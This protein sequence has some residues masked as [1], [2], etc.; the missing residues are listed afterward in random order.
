MEKKYPSRGL[1]QKRLQKF[2][3][4]MTLKIFILSVSLSSI[5]VPG[6]SQSRYDVK[7][8]GQD[9]LDVLVWL[10]DNSNYRFIYRKDVVKDVKVG[11]LDM[12]QASMEQILDRVLIDNGFEYDLDADNVVVVRKSRVQAPQQTRQTVSVTGT[13]KDSNGNP[14]AGVSVIVKNTKN[15]V[16]TDASGNFRISMA[17]GDVLTFS[18]LGKKTREVVYHN[19]QSINVVMEE[20]V[21]KVADVVVTGIFNRPK[22]SFTGSVTMV[23][24]DELQ[25]A[26]TRSVLTSLANIDPSF[27]LIDNINVGADPNALPNIVIRGETSIST[28]VRDLQSGSQSLT[29]LPL[30]IMDGFEVSLETVNDLDDNLIENVMIFKDANATALYGS[31]GS[32]G[33]VVITL[34]RPEPGKLR[35]SYTGRLN[36]EAPDLSY[37]N[38]M[39]AR[40]KLQYE[41]AAGLYSYDRADDEQLLMQLY[42][43]RLTEV[44]RGVDTYWIRFPVRVAAGHS[45]S[46]RLDGG[47]N[48]IRYSIDLSYNNVQGTM[49]GSDRNTVSGGMG[50]QYELG[51]LLF[52]NDL[53][54]TYSKGDNSPYGSFSD[55]AAVNSYYT[56]YDDEG[57]LKKIL[58]GR[59]VYQS[60]YSSSRP[61][62]SNIIYNP[63]YDALLDQI[64]SSQ[65][66]N[67]RNNF[68]VDWHIAEGLTFRGSLGVNARFDRSDRFYPSTHTMFADYTGDDIGRKGRYVYGT[69]EGLDYTARTTIDYVK[70]FDKHQL[71]AGLSANLSQYGFESYSFTGEGISNPNMDFLGMASQYL[72]GGSPEG[73][74][75]ISRTAGLSANVVYTFDNRFFV[76]ATGSFA[77][78]S[79][80]GANRR[81]APFASIGVGWN[82]HH[83]AFANELDWISELRPRISYGVDGSQNFSTYQALT[84]FRDYGDLT[85]SGWNGVYIVAMGNNDL[86]WQTTYK[87]NAGLDINILH[88]RV[89]ITLDY[90]NNMT[91]DL[92]CDV[93]LPTSSGFS[94]FRANVGRVSNVGFEIGANAFVIRDR[95]RTISW[96]V[97]G[98]IFHNRNRIEKISN[99]L[100][101]LNERTLRSDGADPSLI[102][103]EGKS[104]NTL[105]AVPSLGIDPANGKEIFVKKDGTLTYTWSAS[106]KADCG[107]SEPKFSGSINTMFVYRKFE[108]SAIFS[109]QFGGK[110][111]N[112]TL[113]SRLEDI[114]PYQNADR[115][116]LYE[117]WQT[118]G[119]FAKY[120]SIQD[121]SRTRS[122]SRFIQ[123]DNRLRFNTLSVG[124]TFDASRMKRLGLDFLKLSGNMEDI[125]HLSSIKRERGLNY[126]E[127]H[128]FSI[129]LQAR[130]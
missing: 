58:E 8:T 17:P 80:F 22:E 64:N 93:T 34:R 87:F 13:V 45:H 5:S 6:W 68:S 47:R 39:N 82:L 122:S 62:Q 95:E 40:E 111:Y 18:F 26:G 1:V 120:K 25:Q 57:N 88:R 85:Y 24:R 21:M 19:Q 71:S 99:T 130:F 106:D 20:S 46:L 29:N 124:Y 119:V 36:V 42:N 102:Y 11:N 30:F 12:T 35:V 91:R 104:L 114:S 27:R 83:E 37:Y 115:R 113:V 41:K 50:L 96:S 108:L 67:I 94:S 63:L 75:S 38:L 123:N 117:R 69:G 23:S 15:G 77:G 3:L 105:Y 78:S 55:W 61:Y 7:F 31:R 121:F 116:A 59:Y 128:K 33:V 73:T 43:A 28:S 65:Y 112:Q 84:T 74:E 66:T 76:N 90:Y 81:W 109:Y 72:R 100:K 127:S 53:K 86:R 16:V 110:A 2:L 49:K 129:S 97:G 60:L 126:P 79:Q 107:L 51:K 89:S 54:I 103:E 10:Q 48:E 118:P 44:E 125:F 70:S 98:S 56:P 9:L 32:N 14:L 52:K 101:Y 92:V 4:F